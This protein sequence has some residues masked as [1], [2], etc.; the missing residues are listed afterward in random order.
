MRVRGTGGLAAG[1][2]EGVKR[3]KEVAATSAL[4]SVF[5]S[6]SVCGSNVGVFMSGKE[7]RTREGSERGVMEAV[8]QPP[9]AAQHAG[10]CV[11][12]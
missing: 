5:K 7:G 2:K 4:P 9:R 6:E 1:S 3:R 8:S 10:V 12:G 11:F